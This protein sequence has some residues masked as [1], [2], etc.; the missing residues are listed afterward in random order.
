MQNIPFR[1]LNEQ[2]AGPE[3]PALPLELVR[4]SKY[5]KPF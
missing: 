3:H 2:A 1:G 4:Q 5:F